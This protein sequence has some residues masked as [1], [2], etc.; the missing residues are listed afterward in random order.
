MF[1]LETSG[2]TFADLQLSPAQCDQIAS[3][4]PPVSSGRGGIR[5]LLSHPT[6]LRLLLRR[7]LGEYLCSVTGRELVAVK[8]TFF[9][10]SL[11]ANWRAQWHQDRSVSVR[12]R[13]DV[14]GYGPWNTKAGYV[15]VDA[16]ATVLGQ[17]IAAR[18]YLDACGPANG[19]LH[20]IPGSHRLGKVREEHIAAIVK[21][22]QRA[23]ICAQRGMIFVMRPLLLHSS[24][25]S[26]VA[27]HRRVL[28]I[29]FAPRES[30]SPL[31]WETAIALRRAA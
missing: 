14:P 20:V 7:Q 12:E 22:S 27:E 9:D 17:M 4:I 21:Q 28:H 29:E 10:K 13:A 11:D 2:C 15:R 3:T 25:P 30:I 18:I 8:A 26:L 23:E 1:D 6:V 5:H 31:S 19:P 16:P 24:I